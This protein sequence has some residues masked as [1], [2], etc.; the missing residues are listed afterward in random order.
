MDY[1]QRKWI[2]RITEGIIKHKI[3]LLGNPYAIIQLED[4]F[5]DYE[6]AQSIYKYLVEME[7]IDE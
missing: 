3:K 1:K 6:L 4:N 5:D 7:M 2:D